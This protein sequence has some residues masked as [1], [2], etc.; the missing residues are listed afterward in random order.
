MS[1][2]FLLW[3]ALVA[4]PS[5]GLSGPVNHPTTFSRNW[6]ETSV[7]DF[8]DGMV[9]PMMYVSHREDADPDSGAVEFFA[10]FDLDNNGYFDLACADDSGPYLRIY[11]GTAAGYNTMHVRR[12]P[13]PGGGNVDFADLNLDGYAEM[14]HSGWRS[15]HVTIYWGTDSGP[16]PDDTTQLAITGQS[17]AVAVY[18]LDRDSYLDII[19]GSDDGN[20]YIFWGAPGGYSSANR[21]SIFVNGSIGHNIEVADFDKDGY[22]DIALSLWSRNRAPIIYWG[23]GRTPRTITWLNISPNNPHGITVADLNQDD[24]LDI[25]YT[26]YDTVTTAY[27]YYG[28]EFGFPLGNREVIHPGQCYGGSAAV[29]WN[30]DKLLD[31]VFFRGNW[32]TSTTWRPRV[33]YN[34]IDSLPHFSDERL[35]AC[36]EYWGIALGLS[37][38]CVSVSAPLLA[39]LSPLTPG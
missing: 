36:C 16:S 30:A 8:R 13:V 6:T 27:I 15:G 17:E 9:D 32:G 19:A 22:G 21:T 11:F 33:F 7:A 38:G 37:K 14:V 34:R 10:R 26:G 5:V 2:H 28:S 24:W 35:C 25:V 3:A 18:D 39:G 4:Q 20:V 31:L 12:Y 1:V 23:P 29:L